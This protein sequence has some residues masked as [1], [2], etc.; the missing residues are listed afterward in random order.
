MPILKAQKAEKI[1]TDKLVG[2]TM[3]IVTEML[4]IIVSRTGMDTN[5]HGM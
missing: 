4:D 2:E 1:S 5:Y 3:D